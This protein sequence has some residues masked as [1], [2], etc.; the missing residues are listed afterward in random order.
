MLKIKLVD[1]MRR[2]FDEWGAGHNHL[3]DKDLLENIPKFKRIMRLGGPSENEIK[4]A[5]NL[6]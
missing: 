2:L 4:Q 1:A 5:L 6:K 3:S